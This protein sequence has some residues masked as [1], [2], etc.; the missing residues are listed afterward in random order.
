MDFYF[1]SMPVP[2][3]ISILLIALAAFIAVAK[4]KLTI[5]GGI[6]GYLVACA[7][8]AGAAINGVILLGLFFL[9]GT[10]ATSWGKGVKHSHN[11]DDNNGGKRTA[12][13]VLANGSVAGVCGI[14][15]YIF[16]QHHELLVIMLASSLSSATADT[17]SSE[18]G[19]VYG[20]R[21]YNMLT[22]RKDIRGENGV[23]SLEGTLFGLAGS[24]IM[25]YA[26]CFHYGWQW[27]HV[28]VVAGTVGNIVDSLLGAALERKGYIKNNAVNLL[29]TIAAALTALCIYFL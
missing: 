5:L 25:A 3:I 20:K 7:I 21:F 6:T 27:F 1:Y 28:I 23:V 16:P 14:L 8:Y 15:A 29:N 17:L 10:L 13:Q 26:Y 2:H 19:T 9:L 12:A 18:L 4:D 22:F 24:A 11:A